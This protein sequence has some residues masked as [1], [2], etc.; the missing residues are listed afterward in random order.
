MN[1]KYLVILL[2]GLISF[3]TFNLPI[4]AQKFTVVKDFETVQTEIN[5]K[6]E[7]IQTI[8]S[9]FLQEKHLGFLTEPIKSEGLFRY[10]KENQL[11]WEYIMP[12]QYLIL[13]NGN[14]IIIKDK[15]KR[16]EFDANSNSI[17]KQINDLMLG[18]IKGNLGKNKDYSMSLQESPKQYKLMLTPQNVSL[19][20]YISCVEIYFEKSDLAVSF[21]K[22]VEST[23]DFTTI[24]F[25]ERKFNEPIDDATFYTN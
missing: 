9:Y 24:Q 5:K 22:I 23:G 8:K 14:K 10:K 11:R 18:A 3:L 17:F 2:A 21:I 15:N 4:K 19:K 13:F 6:A 1:E 25:T 16:N 12:F 20:S 7:S